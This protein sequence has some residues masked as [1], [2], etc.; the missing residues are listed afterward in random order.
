MSFGKANTEKVLDDLLLKMAETSE[1]NDLTIEQRC[2][3]AEVIVKIAELRVD[4]ER[5]RAL[6]ATTDRLSPYARSRNQALRE[7]GTE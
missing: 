2:R 6:D 7:R 3:V 1:R 5:R 4:E